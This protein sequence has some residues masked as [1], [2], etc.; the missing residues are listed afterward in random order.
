MRI[1]KRRMIGVRPRRLL[2]GVFVVLGSAVSVGLLGAAAVYAVPPTTAFR[3]VYDAD[4]QLKA[5]ISPSTETA[6]YSWDPVGNLLSLGKASSKK[7]SVVELAPAHGPVGETVTI[8]GTGFSTT[9]AN[10]TVKFNG[11]KATVSA[12]TAV[13]LTVKVPSGATSGAVSVQTTTE[14]PVSSEQSFTVAASPAPSVTSLSTTLAAPG[15]EVTI[16]G[17]GFESTLYGNDVAVNRTRPEVLSQSSSAIKFRVPEGTG[18]GHVSVATAQGSSIGPVLFIPPVGIAASKVG[19]TG[20]MSIGEAKT[21]S[22]SSGSANVALESFEGTARQRVSLETSE[23]TI[24]RGAVR[25]VG[26][27]GK[28]LPQEG[29]GS[30]ENFGQQQPK[31]YGPVTLPSTGT[32][33]IV[34]A[35]EG[36]FTGSLKLSTYVV[37]DIKGSLTPTTEGNS[38]AVSL[39]TPGQRALYTVAITAN[40]AVSLK[41]SETKFVGSG[42]VNLEWVNPEGRVIYDNE[43]L[44]GTNNKFFKQV[45][46]PTAG[47]YTLIVNPASGTVGSMTL[48]AYNASDVTGTLTPTPSCETKTITISAPGQHGV[49]TFE[50]TANQRVSLFATEETIT[51]GWVSVYNSEGT[52]VNQ[53]I[54]FGEHV[55]KLWGAATLGSTGKYTIV[56]EGEEAYTGSIHLAACLVTDIKGSLTPTEEGDSTP[57]SITTPGQRA[58][59]TLAGSPGEI[60]SLT[61]SEMKFSEIVNVELFN[62]TSENIFGYGFGPTENTLLKQIKLSAAGTYTLELDPRNGGTGSMTLT[63]Y[64]ASDVTGSITPSVEGETKTVSIGAPG[65]YARYT[66]AGESGHTITLKAKESTI[67][68]GTISLLNPEGAK[69]AG[70]EA[71]FSSSTG[72]SVEPTLS[73]TGTY[74]IL[75]EPGGSDTGSVKLTAY[76]GSHPLIVRRPVSATGETPPR[77]LRAAN[78]RPTPREGDEWLVDDIAGSLSTQSTGTPTVVLHPS[79]VRGSFVRP[80][81]SRKVVAGSAITPAMRA[82]RPLRGQLGAQLAGDDGHTHASQT[83]WARIA[84]LEGLPGETAV[85]GQVLAQDGLPLVGVHVAIE[86]TYIAA[87]TDQAGRFI[88]TGHVASGHHVLLVTGEGLPTGQR[89]GTY[90]IGLRITAHR[91]SILPYTIWLTP[92][93]PAGNWHVDSPTTRETRLTT[94]QIPGLEIRIPAGSVITN[95]A[96]HIV[97]DLNIT[98]IP[99]ERPPFP[100]PAFVSIPLYFTAQPGATWLSKGAQIVYPNWGHQAPG[101]HVDFWNYSPKQGW[102]VYGMGTVTPNGKQIMPDPGTRIWEFS[103]AMTETEPNPPSSSPTSGG[104]FAGGDPVDLRTGLFVYHKKDLVIPDVIPITIERTY[105]QSDSNSYSFGVGMTNLYNMRL[106]SNKQFKEV[107]LVLPDGATIKYL[108]TSPGEGYFDSEFAATSTPGMYYASTLKWSVLDNGWHLTLTNG[109]TYVFGNEGPLQAIRDRSGDQLTLTHEE[110][111]RGKITQITSPHGRW[112]KFTY[113]SDTRITEIKDNAGQSLKYKY[114]SSG[115]LESTTDPAGRTTF[116]EYNGAGEMT[117]VK[118]GRGKTYVKNEYESHGRVSKETLGNEGT[119]TFSYTEGSGEQVESATVTDPRKTQ[120][121]ATFNSESF[122]T[123]EIN[124]LGTSI[125]EKTTYEPQ[126]G[127]GLPLSVTD[128][129]GRKTT[130]KYDSAGNITQE[131]LLAGT[132]SARTLEYTYEPNTN[133]QTSFTNAL[134]Q[135][136]TYHYAEHGEL[137]SVTDPLSHK[138]SYEYNSEGQPT[139]IENALGKKTKLGYQFG[140]LTSVTDPLGRT[141]KQFVDQL[142]R[143][144]STTTPGGQRTVYERNG[145][146][147]VTKLTNPLGA[148]SIYEYDGDGNLTATTDPN[149]HKGTSSYSPMDLLE[150]ETDALEHTAKGVYDQDGNLIE[151]TTRDGKLDKFTYDALNRLTEARYSVSG[152]T[153]ESTIKYE[154]DLG[155]RLTK[156][157]DSATGTYTPEYDEFNRLKSIATPNGTITYEYNEANERTTMKVPGQEPVKYSHDEAGRLTEVKRGSE[158]VVL[159]YDEANR[160]TST[161]LP[162]GIEEQYGYDEAN[163]LASIVYKKGATKLGELDYAYNSEGLREAI[164]GSYARLGLPEA[165]SSAVYNADNE[166]TERNGKKPGYDNEGNLTSDGSSEYKWNARGQLAEITGAIKAAFAYDPVGRRTSKTLSG[167]TTKLLYDGPNVIQETQGSS[168]ANMLTGL[169]VDEIFA[170]TTSKATESLL[171][172]ALGSTIALGGSTGKAETSYTYDPFG[173]TTKEGTASEN[174]FQYT[175]RENDGNGLYNYRARYYSPAAARFTSQDP[176][177]QEGSG[178]NLYRYADDSPINATDPYGTSLNPPTP[179]GEEGGGGADGSRGSSGGGI[180]AGGGFGSGGPGGGAGFGSGP[181]SC[182]GGGKGPG[183]GP[184]AG[185]IEEEARCHAYEKLEGME[186]EAREH[187]REEAHHNP[188]EYLEA[189]GKVIIKVKEEAREWWQSHTPECP[190]NQLPNG[191]GCQRRPP[192]E[193][194]GSPPPSPPPVPVG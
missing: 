139:A 49:Y 39:P 107:Y 121:K 189:I 19:V 41:T 59:Y 101:Q 171:T 55:P 98:A 110:G 170:R 38:T 27:E 175:G 77:P 111:Q 176:T 79:A 117:A 97:Q 82:F 108:R 105:R 42:D 132:S 181:G 32:Y 173:A 58:I 18:G 194:P 34:V 156:I 147:Q 50:G 109:T 154:Y 80:R 54:S 174:P 118:D 52:L 150:S 37:S 94:P 24:T 68:N 172:D 190:P 100:L 83:P 123:S 165:I 69:V 184:G 136:T 88:L 146:G 75:L 187:D 142:G 13:L 12:A 23:E 177:G 122:P 191:S 103:G 47:T 51:A 56:V 183:G 114:T 127:T 35:P 22:V 152:E 144:A 166:Q 159:H 63:V 64:N 180:S 11:T 99:V 116:Y 17:S 149:K 71:S 36:E 96:G 61:S 160:P 25:I 153:A 3:Y 134:K 73:A 78:T 26:P 155:N 1:A 148:E 164:W 20:T 74:T 137:Q 40:E 104:G 124:A 48:T 91:T 157:I 102:Y 129:L 33:T 182:S 72:A 186:E 161:T 81:V 93:D 145:D 60:L 43:E 8:S 31:L 53:P 95:R 90:Q 126:A 119:Y 2:M 89:Y 7:L 163:E 28:T 16:S 130:F 120:R 85:S 44:Y 4:G 128:P 86:G 151:L 65:Q 30:Q 29:T 131:T 6:F 138:T 185:G 141:T 112:V 125:E 10:D 57:L 76:L 167:T 45:R 70:S 178:V 158:T 113:D 15:S 168:T 179:G 87:Q 193:A 115:L 5:A 188:W 133:E 92:L 135:K 192:D 9:K 62:P 84:P 46:F 143:V 67:A 140:D 162:D 14:G 21:V 169:S 66:F 106:W